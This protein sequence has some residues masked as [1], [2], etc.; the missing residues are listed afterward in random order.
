MMPIQDQ[1]KANSVAKSALDDA[2]K[3][4]NADRTANDVDKK[5]EQKD[6]NDAEKKR[7]EEGESGGQECIG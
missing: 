2:E 3:K 6:A 7:I 4:I 1:K 5:L